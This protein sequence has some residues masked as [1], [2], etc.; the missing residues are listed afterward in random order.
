[1]DN[2]NLF[3]NVLNL[4]FEKYSNNISREYVERKVLKEE[5]LY[6]S[7]KKLIDDFFIFYNKLEKKRKMK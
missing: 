4:S 7:N 3:N 5:D 6:K 2:L 1:M